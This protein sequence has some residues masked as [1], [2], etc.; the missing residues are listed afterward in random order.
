MACARTVFVYARRNTPG[1]NVVRIF[2][3]C[4]CSRVT[5]HCFEHCGVLIYQ[6][7]LFS[8]GVFL[9]STGTAV[10]SGNQYHWTSTAWSKCSKNCGTDGIRERTVRCENY[11]TQQRALDSMCVGTVES[12]ENCHR[13]ECESIVGV[14]GIILL[15][16]HSYIN[17]TAAHV[18]SFEDTVESELASA[19]NVPTTRFRVV[20][21]HDGGYWTLDEGGEGGS[22]SAGSGWLELTYVRFIVLPPTTNSADTVETIIT[23]L[24]EQ[25]KVRHWCM[26]RQWMRWLLTWLFLPPLDVFRTRNP[27]FAPTGVLFEEWCRRMV[28]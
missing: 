24:N 12:F 27:N 5:A 14:G 4:C 23:S 3:L 26:V 13:F 19:T 8:L 16:P 6:P 21:S 11:E 20:L 10:S 28:L 1:R 9:F 18:A 2:L 25:S 22:G 7:A 17:T 15:M